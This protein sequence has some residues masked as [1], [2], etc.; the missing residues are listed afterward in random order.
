VDLPNP[1]K[2]SVVEIKVSDIKSRVRLRTP[3]DN[4]IKEIA[5]SIKTCGLMH[6][7]TIDTENYIVAGFHRWSAYKLLGYETIPSIISDTSALYNKLK[8]ID[9]NL[10]RNEI[11]HLETGVHIRERENILEQLGVRM[12]RG[13]NQYS[14]GMITTTELAEQVGMSNKIYRL[15]RQ[16]ADIHPEVQ[17][18]LIG[19]EWAKNMMDMV[20]LSRETDDIQRKVADLLVSGSCRTFKRAYATATLSDYRSE[21]GYQINFDVKER[22][23]IPQSIM[24]FKKAGSD[25]QKV[26][27]LITHS[28]ELDLVKRRDFMKGQS[29]IP[30]YGMSA[31]LAEFLI[32]YYTPEGGLVLDQFCG[33]GTIGLACLYH[34]RRFVGYDL[35]KKNLDLIRQV[36]EKHLGANDDNLTL[37]HSDGITLK[38]YE[39]K[40]EYFDAIV[41]DPAYVL[42]AEKYSDDEREL[43]SKSHDEYMKC[44]KLN[45]QRCY[46]LIKTSSIEEKRFYPVIF[47]VSHGRKGDDG[48][49]DMDFDFQM[50]ARECG[51]KLWD[52]LTNQLHTPFA[53]VNFQRNYIHKYVQKNYEVNLV[54]CKFK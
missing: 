28:S 31:D 2:L 37:H 42:K 46:D 51:F 23:G 15:K 18:L 50:V 5:D 36:S 48:I 33:R 7:I 17:D 8:E 19:T 3:D 49:T 52:K 16:I 25:L 32:T 11:D 53:S 43:G 39:G 9:E 40:E 27:E 13:G 6:P 54:F 26:C 4:K 14:K 45:F 29:D 22:W 20:K 30:I 38:E 12:K 41:T 1:A 10:K 21:Y 24:R 34:S 35:T 47:K 44:I